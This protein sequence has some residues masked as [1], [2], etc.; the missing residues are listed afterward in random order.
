MSCFQWLF[1]KREEEAT[2][3]PTP[4]EGAWICTCSPT[5]DLTEFGQVPPDRVPLSTQ[6][7]LHDCDEARE[8]GPE[9]FRRAEPMSI[10]PTPVSSLAMR[11]H[12]Y[13][14]LLAAKRGCGCSARAPADSKISKKTMPRAQPVLSQPQQW[15]HLRLVSTEVA[16]SKAAIG[17]ML[18]REAFVFDVVSN[19]S[20]P[21]TPTTRAATSSLPSSPDINA[22]VVDA[23]NALAAALPPEDGK[24]DA[25]LS[26]E[27]VER[28]KEI[29]RVATAPTVQPP[30]GASKVR[31]CAAKSRIQAPAEYTLEMQLQ[32]NAQRIRLL[33]EAS[34]LQDLVAASAHYRDGVAGRKE[35]LDHEGLLQYVYGEFD[36][37]DCELRESKADLIRSLM[38]R[39]SM[40]VDEACFAEDDAKERVMTESEMKANCA[41]PG[42]LCAECRLQRRVQGFDFDQTISK[43]HVFKQLAGWELGVDAPQ[44]LSERQKISQVT[45]AVNSF[46]VHGCKLSVPG[47]PESA[48]VEAE[49]CCD[50]M[51]LRILR[52]AFGKVRAKEPPQP[53]EPA[54]LAKEATEETSKGA[55][56]GTDVNVAEPEALVEPP[57]GCEA[58]S[59][60]AQGQIAGKVHEVPQFRIYLMMYDV[61]HG[62]A[63]RYSN[64]LLGEHLEAVWHTG[65]VVEWGQASEFWFGGNIEE[66][67]PGRSPFGPPTDKRFLGYTK[68]TR[69]QVFQFFDRLMVIDRNYDGQHYNLMTN[70]CNHFSD[71]LLMFLRNEQIP[72]DIR[73]QPKLV[74]RRLRGQVLCYLLGLHWWC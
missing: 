27:L 31:R 15:M 38:S 17:L 63:A 62:R 43:I 33:E 67:E 34:I 70:N 42:A 52:A 56:G 54:E 21:T 1:R 22:D 28:F 60:A 30:S 11:S 35:D 39:Q 49:P 12:T 37:S 69:E 66:S 44:A 18:L 9:A 32:E 61:S 48:R 19:D 55:A 57:S 16:R 14:V 10:R 13:P 45:H 2:Q 6:K 74:T 59:Q 72:E 7:L 3:A 46:D 5:E 25:R 65:L 23:Q 50:F 40:A 41:S 20:A 71:R 68:K 47:V 58:A 53:A 64:I 4:S 24:E 51:R 8:N 36:S 26:P 73:K 29:V